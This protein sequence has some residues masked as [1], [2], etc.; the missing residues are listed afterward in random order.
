MYQILIV[1]DES[2]ER[3]GLQ[4]MLGELNYQL[5]VYQAAD[6]EEARQLI[7]SGIV[8]DILIT[9]IRMPFMDGLTLSE[10][11]CSQ[12]P[13]TYI[14]ISSAYDSFSYA[15]RA[16]RA[17]ATD[18]LL[19]PIEPQELLALMERLLKKCE[20]THKGVSAYEPPVLSS[21]PSERHL[22]R[23]VRQLIAA[24]YMKP[25]GVDHIARELNLSPNYISRVFRS[26][27]NE[28]ILKY[29]IRFRLEKA[30][31]LLRVST[32]SINEISSLVGYMTPAY[33]SQA[34]RR[35]YGLTPSE[36][37]EEKGE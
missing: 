1:D 2:V 19:K 10:W 20:Q 11:I 30:S 28:P 23:K 31:E 7:E 24:N 13:Y 27:T 12:Y 26:E 15:Q 5:D 36:Y 8:P 18:Y 29:L 34:F 25:I 35:Q 16:I 14:V 22:V 32:K 6:G 3:N 4:R 9:D 17:C 33:F 21:D 37:R